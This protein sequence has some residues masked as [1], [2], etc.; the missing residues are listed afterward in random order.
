MIE[1]KQLFRKREEYTIYFV[2]HY[3]SETGILIEFSIRFFLATKQFAKD[4]KEAIKQRR[5][6]S[7]PEESV[8]S[9]VEIYPTKNH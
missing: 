6:I 1:E 4:L 5:K 3:R 7:F 9:L 2:P 8:Q